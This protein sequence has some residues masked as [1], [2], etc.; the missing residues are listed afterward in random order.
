MEDECVELKNI[1]YQTMLLNKKVAEKPRAQNNVCE[2]SEFL[3][4]EKTRDKNL[5][6]TKLEKATKLKKLAAFAKTFP[7]KYSNTLK[8]YLF[9]CLE[10]KRLQ[11]KKDVNYNIT[12]GKIKSI[13]GLTLNKAKGRY[14]LKSV[15]KG[16]TLKCLAPKRHR[17]KQR[18]AKTAKTTKNGKQKKT[19]KLEI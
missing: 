1:N 12:E 14:T 9:Q 11:R 13:V 6:W 8:D 10:R 16:S 5:P 18:K 7:A 4:R 19:E 17:S 15:G 2:V 3:K